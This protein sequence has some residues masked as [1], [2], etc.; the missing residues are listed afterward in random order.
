MHGY[1]CIIPSMFGFMDFYTE[2]YWENDKKG[3]A[4]GIYLVIRISKKNCLGFFWFFYDFLGILEP[5]AI[6]WHLRNNEKRKKKTNS[7]HWASLAREPAA[8]GHV[9]PAQPSSWDAPSPTRQPGRERR[10][11]PWRRPGQPGAAGSEAV[12]RWHHKREGGMAVPF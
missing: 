12:N 7:G 9:R 4:L 8:N 1:F 11:G 2:K 5:W 10:V 6:F 3:Q